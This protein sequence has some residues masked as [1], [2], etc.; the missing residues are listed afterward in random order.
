[1]TNAV[2]H[3]HASEVRI[4]V[5]IVNELV[6]VTVDDDG[7]GGATLRPGGGIAGLRE[8]VTEMG[9]RLTV[10]SPLGEGT[11]IVGLIPVLTR[12]STVMR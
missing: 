5:R 8:R 11:R 4:S 10:T 1:V 3:A 7:G 9:G 6:E 2:K 12:A